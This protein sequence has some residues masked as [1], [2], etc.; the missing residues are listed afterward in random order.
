MRDSLQFIGQIS[1]MDICPFE[2]FDKEAGGTAW[3]GTKCKRAGMDLWSASR[4]AGCLWR[5]A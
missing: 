1:V 4:G 2:R 5:A 3:S